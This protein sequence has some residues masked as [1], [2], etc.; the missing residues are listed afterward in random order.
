MR[1]QV[2]SC[3]ST[4]NRQRQLTIADSGKTSDL[5]AS[6]RLAQTG[7]I[8]ASHTTLWT[9]TGYMIHDTCLLGRAVVQARVRGLCHGGTARYSAMKPQ[10]LPAATADGQLVI[11]QS[12]YIDS[13]R[14]VKGIQQQMNKPSRSG[15]G[16]ELSTGCNV[17]RGGLTRV[18]CV[19]D[20]L[21]AQLIHQKT[22]GRPTFIEDTTLES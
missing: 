21:H 6:G 13:A 9:V 20:P 3:L 4:V 10:K 17:G 18:K 14:K 2:Q 16:G 1:T 22:V 7:K 12:G 15:P 5:A 19:R 8:L 11:S